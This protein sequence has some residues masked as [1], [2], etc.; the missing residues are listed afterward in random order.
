MTDGAM[1]QTENKEPV[2]ACLFDL[3]GVLVFTDRCHYLAWKSVADEN[4]LDFNET[5][6]LRL[7]GIPRPESL[8]E[9]LKYN[10]IELADAEKARLADLKNA[11]YVQMLQ[12]IGENDV[13]PG[14]FA[15]IRTLRN[16]GIRIALCSSSKNARLVLESWVSGICLTQPSQAMIS[17]RQS[18]TPKS[19]SP[20]QP[21]LVFRRLPA[22]SLRIPW[23]AFGGQLPQACKRLASETARSLAAWLTAVWIPMRNSTR[24]PSGFGKCEAGKKQMHKQM[25]AKRKRR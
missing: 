18:R 16:R 19:F 1:K 10:H 15:L 8:N 13:Y 11:R 4:G 6:N 24:T 17:G 14:A 25:T 9:I 20:P 12:G 7:R 21:G 5:V 23:R 2:R 22:W 3:D